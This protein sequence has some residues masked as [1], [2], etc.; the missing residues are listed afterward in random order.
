MKAL[1]F[2]LIHTYTDV[3]RDEREKLLFVEQEEIYESIL[4]FLSMIFFVKARSESFL[5]DLEI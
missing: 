3:I 5:G 2:R 1:H 4:I